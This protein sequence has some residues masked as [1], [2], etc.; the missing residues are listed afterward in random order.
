VD[1]NAAVH[2]EFGSL[3]A[4]SAPIAKGAT[5]EILQPAIHGISTTR[6]TKRIMQKKRKS[7]TEYFIVL[8]GIPT[9]VDFSSMGKGPVED[10]SL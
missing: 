4:T 3:A 10:T 6:A 9:E 2:F 8:R 5:A 1:W 7:G